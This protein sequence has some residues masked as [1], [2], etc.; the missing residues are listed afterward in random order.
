MTIIV[1]I[2]LINEKSCFVHNFVMLDCVK[3]YK[4]HKL[5]ATARLV[6]KPDWGVN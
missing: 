5:L 1:L 3:F 4:T 2:I 6:K